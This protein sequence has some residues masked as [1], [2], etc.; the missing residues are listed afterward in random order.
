MTQINGL[1]SL[2]TSRTM[3]G[4]GAQGVEGGAN[5]GESTDRAQGRQDNVSLSDRGR[6]VG[7]AASAVRTAADVRADKVA[8]LKA[9][10][11]NGTYHGD[12][13][14]VAARLMRTGT[15]E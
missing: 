1:G 14:G 15:F 3:Q 10:I 9:A 11:T 12:D 13:T 2:A 5:G 6:I 4:Q 8:A 7:L